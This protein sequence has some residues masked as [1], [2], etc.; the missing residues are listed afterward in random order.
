MEARA[1]M[2]QKSPRR[3]FGFLDVFS[4]IGG[5]YTQVT[6]SYLA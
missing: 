5:L 4:S 6:N 3:L 1:I 2:T